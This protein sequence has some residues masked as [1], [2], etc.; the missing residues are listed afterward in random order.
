MDL[1]TLEVDDRYEVSPETLKGLISRVGPEEFLD[2]LRSGRK[3]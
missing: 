3:R 2:A 1:D